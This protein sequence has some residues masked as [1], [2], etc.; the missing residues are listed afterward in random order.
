M[1]SN[2][3]VPV[4]NTRHRCRLAAVAAALVVSLGSASQASAEC[5]AD[6]VVENKKP[7]AI[8]VLRFEYTV[9]SK[10]FTEPLA[11][12]RLAVGERETWRT[13]NLAH[14]N[15]GQ[16]ITTTRVEFKEDTSGKGSPIGDPYGPAKWSDYHDHSPTYICFDGRDYYV[17]VE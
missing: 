14:V 12:K 10:T 2:L 17:S 3:N 1:K 4:I 8:K 6:V 13:Q 5:A 16:V 15:D 11:N 9:G 7:R